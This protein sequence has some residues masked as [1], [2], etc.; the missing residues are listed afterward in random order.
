[1]ATSRVAACIVE[2]KH[3]H[4]PRCAICVA[5]RRLIADGAGVDDASIAGSIERTGPDRLEGWCWC[6]ARPGERLGVDI[7]LDGMLVASTTA[8][9]FRRDLAQ[10][11]VGD[12]RHGFAVQIPDSPDTGNGQLDGAALVELREQS[13]CRVVARRRQRRPEHTSSEHRRLDLLDALLAP[14]RRAAATPDGQAPAADLRRL[15]A[16]LGDRLAAQAARATIK[17]GVVDP[18]GLAAQGMIREMGVLQ[19]PMSFA[20]AVSVLLHAAGEVEQTRRAVGILAPWIEATG[21]ELLVVDDWSDSRTALLSIVVGN[22][23][24]VRA[25]GTFAAGAN[26]AALAARG[27]TLVFPDIGLADFR[28]V[29]DPLPSWKN[30]VVLGPAVLRAARC[31]GVLDLLKPVRAVGAQGLLL[32]VR[33]DVFHDLNGFDPAMAGDAALA[34]LDF[35]LKATLLGLEVA[36]SEWPFHG[37]ARVA[38]SLDAVAMARFAAR[39]RVPCCAVH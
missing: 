36:G 13:S 14:V 23:A 5:R 25:A 27:T 18:I 35:G 1:M 6:P 17:G 16:A 15:M 8:A 2:L 9:L 38:P 28:G 10:S 21:A 31:I 39:W 3:S 26:A 34:A 24:F 33:R 11:G 7:L 32:S 30:A 29:F 19:L 22:L 37:N 4:Q 12:G 20:P